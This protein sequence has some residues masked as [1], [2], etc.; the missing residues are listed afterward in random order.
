MLAARF[1]VVVV[2]VV[3]VFIV[4]VGGSGGFVAP[5]RNDGNKNESS[6][7]LAPSPSEKRSRLCLL[8]SSTR[9]D[10]VPFA[11]FGC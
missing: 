2:V 9:I 1:P 8:R 7:A 4:V 3:V 6:C 5:V 10:V 11:G